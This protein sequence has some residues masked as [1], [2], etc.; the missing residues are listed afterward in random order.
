MLMRYANT[1]ETRQTGSADDERKS[2]EICSDCR[3]RLDINAVT[4][5]HTNTIRP[6][7]L[8]LLLHGRSHR[9]DVIFALL[10]HVVDGVLQL[11]SNVGGRVAVHDVDLFHLL[12]EQATAVADVDRRL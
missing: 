6:A 11:T 1:D 8:L 10:C 2:R 4:S 7:E 5:P 12:F 9:V 3:R